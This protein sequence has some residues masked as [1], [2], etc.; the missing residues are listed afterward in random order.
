MGPCELRLFDGDGTEGH[1][2]NSQP[3][4]Q[5]HKLASWS[6]RVHGGLFTSCGHLLMLA[7]QPNLDHLSAYSLHNSFVAVL[8]WM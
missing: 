6:D 2:D 3:V 5:P 8:D 7:L 4:R 1:A